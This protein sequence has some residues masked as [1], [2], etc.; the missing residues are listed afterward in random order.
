[1]TAEEKIKEVMGLA[2]SFALRQA[3]AREAREL[4]APL[5]K[6]TALY[7]MAS[8]AHDALETKLRELIKDDE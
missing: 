2:K 3:D 7:D 4:D 6:V 1:M 8:L 5:H